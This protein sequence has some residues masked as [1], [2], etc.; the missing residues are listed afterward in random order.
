MIGTLILILIIIIAFIIAPLIIKRILNTALTKMDGHT[1][2]IDHVYIHL[3][4]KKINFGNVTI[5]A[6]GIT[7]PDRPLIHVP[8]ITIFFKWGHSSERF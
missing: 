7:K 5:Y 3:F 6:D 1:G 4:K 8:L 2:H